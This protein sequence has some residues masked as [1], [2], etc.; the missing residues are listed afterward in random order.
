G[1]FGWTWWQGRTTHKEASAA[2]PAPVKRAA[3]RP[4]PP[5]T[6]PA[7]TPATVPAPT[8]TTVAPVTET[9]ETNK[10]LAPV[11]RKTPPAPVPAPVPVPA[12]AARK[13][14]PAGTPP[15]KD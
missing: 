5:S 6:I 3:L 8:T 9:M 12:P 4:Q 15:A 1:W 2:P 10:P 7:P 14:A 13:P 11:Q